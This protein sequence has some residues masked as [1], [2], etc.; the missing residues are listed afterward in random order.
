MNATARRAAAVC[1]RDLQE[2]RKS[3]GFLIV[4]LA[5]AALCV[6]LCVGS[7]LLVHR[8]QQDTAGLSD[9]QRAE[10]VTEVVGGILVENG[11]YGM[12]LLPFPI[13]VWAFAASIVTREKVSGNLETLLAT[14]LRLTEL[15][16]GK[17]LALAG[18]STAIGLLWGLLL[19]VVA[20]GV[21]AVSLSR[22]VVLLSPA[23]AVT[24]VV[25][26]PLLFS[27]M[28]ALVILIALAKDADDAVLPAF[29]LG[30]GAMI[31]IPAGVG[32]GAIDVGSWSF[33]LYQSAAAA[34]L[35]FVIAGLLLI[36]PKEHVVLS[37]RR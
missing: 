26:N 1:S 31:G 33:C 5:F 36:W 11:L 9:E 6:G 35:W 22:F 30:M 7:G 23:A 37:A 19:L 20:H 18:V 29:L 10:V 13:M 32:T 24:A 34:V 14:P 8:L 2:L 3:V 28:C 27:G 12:M 17:T 4:V 16:L 21:V 25:L 15:W